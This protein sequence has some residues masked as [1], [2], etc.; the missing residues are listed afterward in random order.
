[1]NAVFRLF[2]SPLEQGGMA[3]RLP[4]FRINRVC[5]G[6]GAFLKSPLKRGARPSGSCFPFV[7]EWFRGK[8]ELCRGRAASLRVKR[9]RVSSRDNLEALDASATML[10]F[11][12]HACAQATCR[13]LSEYNRRKVT[14]WPKALHHDDETS[15][16]ASAADGI[17]LL[18]LSRRTRENRS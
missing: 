10:S 1:L 6:Q 7:H 13:R 17:P 9:S 4:S 15:R 8:T 18:P 11:P 14:E 16:R 2:P 3:K 12:C 5:R